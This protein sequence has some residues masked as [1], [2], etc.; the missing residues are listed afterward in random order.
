MQNHGFKN[1]LKKLL[2]FL[3]MIAAASPLF[4]KFYRCPIRAFFGIPCPG[5][6]MTRALFSAFTL[7]FEKAFYYHPLFWLVLILVPAGI[8]YYLLGKPYTANVRGAILGV[9]LLFIIVYIIRLI[10]QFGQNE[11]MTLNKNSVIFKI[12]NTICN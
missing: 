8:V 1:R 6:G 7:D 5:C 11:I 12:W 10:V 3:L 2:L 9:A 4:L